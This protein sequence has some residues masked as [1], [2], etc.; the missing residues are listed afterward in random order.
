MPFHVS[1]A[2]RFFTSF[3]LGYALLL[4][5]FPLVSAIF[6]RAVFLFVS[7]S[8]RVVARPFLPPPASRYHFHAIQLFPDIPPFS[9]QSTSLLLLLPKRNRPTT[10]TSDHLP[11]KPKHVRSLHCDPIP[12][13]FPP[14]LRRALES[15]EFLKVGR[16]ESEGCFGGEGGRTEESPACV[17]T[18]VAG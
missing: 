12:L 5:R 16:D 8:L 18:G 17:E 10:T 9:N 14:I 6:L 15:K 4:W 1:F 13:P 7:A 3:G 11:L 2:G